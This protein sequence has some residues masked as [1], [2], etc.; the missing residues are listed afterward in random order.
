MFGIQ[1]VLIEQMKF[2]ISSTLEKTS[3]SKSTTVHFERVQPEV[4]VRKLREPFLKVVDQSERFRPLVLEMKEWPDALTM[5]SRGE[6]TLCTARLKRPKKITFCELCSNDFLDLNTHLNSKEHIQ[7][8]SDPKNW[9]GVDALISK[10]PT[11]EQIIEMKLNN[12]QGS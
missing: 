11:M 3:S 12:S 5:F 6:S 9:T 8:A 2:D 1:I 10:M 4:K 7:N